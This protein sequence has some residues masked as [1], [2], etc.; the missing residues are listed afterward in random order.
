MS[1]I[2]SAI[3]SIRPILSPDDAFDR[4]D[5]NLGGPDYF[6]P[7]DVHEMPFLLFVWIVDAVFCFLVE[8][9]RHKLRMPDGTAW[10]SF[11]TFDGHDFADIL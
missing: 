9:E 5:N 4:F 11:L 7:I 10:Q 8:P 2:S 1:A 3:S 6:A